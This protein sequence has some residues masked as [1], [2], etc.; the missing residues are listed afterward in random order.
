MSSTLDKASQ[1]GCFMNHESM[2]HESMSQWVRSEKI[3]FLVETIK[4]SITI[5]SLLPASARFI[6]DMKSQ[7][8][9]FV[10]SIPGPSATTTCMARR[11][12]FPDTLLEPFKPLDQT[13]HI[14][15]CSIPEVK[16]CPKVVHIGG[17][18]SFKRPRTNVNK[19][20]HNANNECP[21]ILVNQRA[22]KV[23]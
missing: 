8:G 6:S 3:T 18:T 14:T 19:H 9:L 22:L 5:A 10:S 17:C 23:I 7:P 11:I 1:N 16:C 12:A 4:S 20:K 21:K 13:I 2:S 15:R